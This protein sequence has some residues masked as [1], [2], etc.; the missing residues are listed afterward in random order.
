MTKPRKPS[1]FKVNPKKEL[2]NLRKFNYTDDDDVDYG[3]N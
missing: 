3:L 2:Q 1:H